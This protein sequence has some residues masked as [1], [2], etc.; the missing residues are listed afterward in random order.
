MITVGIAVHN[1]E[2][3]IKKVI[4]LWQKEPIDEILIISSESTDNTDNIIKDIAKKD[5]RIHHI[6]ESTKTGKPNAINKILKISKNNIIIMTDGDVYIEPG[7]T[8]H[9]IHHFK[10]KEIGII[11]GHPIPLNP[12]GIY[13]IWMQISC[14]ILHKKRTENIELDVTGNLY[15]IRKNIIKKIPQNTTLDDAYVAYET[16]KNGYNI[17]YEPEAIVYVKGVESLSDFISQKTRTRIGWYQLKHTENIKTT[18]VPSKEL[19][20]IK[21]ILKYIFMPI[22]TIAVPLYLLLN[23][24]TWLNAWWKWKTEKDYLKSWRPAKTTKN[25]N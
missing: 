10:N 8:E 7:A 21:D 23:T 6:I 9:I 16:N 3:T 12:K 24:A 13:G 4:T 25:N 11:A 18:R 19:A 14:D 22:G 5:K 20:Y 15:A 2:N 1:E 17:I